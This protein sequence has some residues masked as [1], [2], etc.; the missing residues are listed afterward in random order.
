MYRRGE[1]DMENI[2]DDIIVQRIFYDILTF[3]KT[4]D[5]YPLNPLVFVISLNCIVFRMR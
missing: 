5:K 2:T 3:E 1:S 4:L